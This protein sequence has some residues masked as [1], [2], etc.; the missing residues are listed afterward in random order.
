MTEQELLELAES[1]GRLIEQ[2]QL[3]PQ[4]DKGRYILGFPFPEVTA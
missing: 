3:P 2:G 1:I 4:D